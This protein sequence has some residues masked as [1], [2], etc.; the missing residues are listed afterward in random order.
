MGV[1]S[2]PVPP[3]VWR[4]FGRAGFTALRVAGLSRTSS[5]TA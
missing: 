3:A 1:V 4:P 2:G 5:R